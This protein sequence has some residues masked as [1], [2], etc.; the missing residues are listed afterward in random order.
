MV[1]ITL[2]A[3]SFPNGGPLPGPPRWPPVLPRFPLTHLWFLYVLL[4]LYVAALVLRTGMVWL[5]PNGRLRARIDGLMGL[6]MRSRFAPA[7]LAVPIGIALC[8]DPTWIAWFGVRTPD[9]SLVTNLQAWI[10]FGTA[11]GFGWLLHRQVDLIRMLER[12]WL[13]NSVLAVVLIAASFFL[14]I[15]AGTPPFR[16]AIASSSSRSRSAT[17]WRSGPRPLR[18]SVLPCAS[19]PASAPRAA[20]SP[21]PPIGSI[22]FTCRS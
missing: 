5:D 20:I 17:R 3:A 11:F 19:C 6:V 18:R 9:S 8:L 15:A 22:S 2:W 12:R 10:G 1:A 7:I 13:L 21:T 4:E 16:S 14:A